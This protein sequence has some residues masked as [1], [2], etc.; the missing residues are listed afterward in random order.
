MSCAPHPGG[1]TALRVGH[2]LKLRRSPQRKAVSVTGRGREYAERGWEGSTSCG[3]FSEAGGHTDGA[4]L[5]G[6]W[7]PA[8]ARWASLSSEDLFNQNQNF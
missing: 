1:N 2:H 3:V 6:R 8:M 4:F 5:S 7:Y